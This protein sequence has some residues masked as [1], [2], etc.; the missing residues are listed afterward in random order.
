[1]DIELVRE[2]LRL[3]TQMIA[4]IQAI[5]PDELPPTPRLVVVKNGD[6]DIGDD[7]P[8]MEKPSRAREGF[9]I[10]WEIN[11]A[12]EEVITE[13]QREQE[14]REKQKQAFFR[15][16]KELSKMPKNLQNKIKDS[17]CR[18]PRLHK[19]AYEKRA[20]INGV[21]V[22]ACH[23][24]LAICEQLFLDELARRISE[25]T[26]PSGSV[27]R[28]SSKIPFA[29]WAKQWF[30]EVYKPSV[31][32]QTYEN[33]LSKYKKHILPYFGDMRVCDISPLDCTR[34]FNE[35]KGQKIERTAE[36]CYGL[37]NRIMRF[38]VDNA[39]IQKNPIESIKPIESIRKNGV[40]LSKQE[41]A[42][43]LSAM[44]GHEFE[45]ILLIALYTGVRPCEYQSVDL[46]EDFITAQN[47]KQKNGKI[48][49][50]K[51]PITPMLR[52][53]MPLIR[54]QLQRSKQLIKR[55]NL[56]NEAFNT[57][58]PNHRMYD[59]RTTFATRCQE[60]G[61]PENVVQIW[62][63]HSAKTLLGR[64]YTKFS[65]EYLLS[66]GNKVKY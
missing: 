36:S 3:M 32:V 50:K 30:E 61:V 20:T 40:P 16:H 11:K 12:H 62:L 7:L 9:P 55:I 66:E 58:C 5:L 13:E 57:F 63:G 56:V 28:I 39:L 60:C 59:L 8:F 17:I 34:F 4:E 29:D 33:E 51:I 31:T 54:E 42:A 65:D 45:P 37:L 43:M 41:E 48:V 25:I 14:L 15:K 27:K 53:H 44:K 46:S 21:N 1:M 23:S 10:L 2:R 19:G 47:M 35:L 22:Y 18:T 52:P 26:A 49:Y 6:Y 64:V 38:A 24:N